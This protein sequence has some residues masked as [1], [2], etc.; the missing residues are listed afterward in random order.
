MIRVDPVRK[1]HAGKMPT[2]TRD[3]FTMRGILGVDIPGGK[4]GTGTSNHWGNNRIDASRFDEHTIKNISM[5]R[6]WVGPQEH[7]F[8]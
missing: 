3:H 1:E 4:Y 7:F 6:V 2:G 5:G 8:H